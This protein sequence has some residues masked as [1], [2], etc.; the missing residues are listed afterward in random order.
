MPGA[1]AG[2]ES[3]AELIDLLLSSQ[4][5]PQWDDLV[6]A[7]LPQMD[8][9]FFQELTS[10]IEAAEASEDKAAAESLLH[11]RTS[12]LDALD[13][14]SQELRDAEDAASLLIMELLEAD[15]LEAA[16]HQ[17]ESELDDVFFMVL[18]RLRQA[19][20][21][22]KNEQRAQRLTQLLDKARDVRESRLPPELRLVSRLLRAD[23]PDG[24]SRLLDESADLV[25]ES[26]LATYDRYV[27]QLG[28][29]ISPEAKERLA[30]IREQLV[31]RVEREDA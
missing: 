1:T 20:L 23:Y 5:Q 27:A 25:Q 30:H 2:L 4:G 15:D 17:K 22:R 14:K 6:A 24:S 28:D 11:L 8:Y 9:A 18:A 29:G 13:R 3:P 19:A 10:R 12:L 16:L 26:L 21:A 7:Y 31:A